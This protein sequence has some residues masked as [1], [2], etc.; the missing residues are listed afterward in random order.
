MPLFRNATNLFNVDLRRRFCYNTSKTTRYSHPI[1]RE[2]NII[3]NKRFILKGNIC[4]TP[5]TGA[6]EIR[7]SAFV[8]CEEGICQGV[9]DA[10]P[11]RY[12][13]LPVIDC[14]DNLILPG[15]R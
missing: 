7:E 8:V 15:R 2:R 4:H 1:P 14:A 9:F 6:L 11:E 3:V 12:E 10:I 5:R 13:A